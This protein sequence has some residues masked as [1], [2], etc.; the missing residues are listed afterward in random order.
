MGG[1]DNV[2]L[3]VGILNDTGSTIQT[4]FDTDLLALGYNPQTYQGNTGQVYIQTA[5]GSVARQS[6]LFE[7]KL[8]K[9]DGTPASG[10]FVE[11][12]VITPSGQINTRLS[13]SRIRR[14]LYFATAPGNQA[15]YVARKKNGIASRLPVV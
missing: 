14:H 1:D 13:G 10:W 5:N 9:P 6:I 3:P 8:R 12:G 11:E 2:I 15:L 7:M 4:L